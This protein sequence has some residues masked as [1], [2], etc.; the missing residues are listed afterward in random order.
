MRSDGRRDVIGII[1]SF[2][3]GLM[4]AAFFG[5]G[6][7]TFYPMPAPYDEEFEE[8]YRREQEVRRLAPDSGLTEEQRQLIDDI[9]AERQ[10]LYQARI[11]LQDRWARNA[12]IILTVLATAAM[13]ISLIRTTLP[14]ISNGLLLGGIFTI[15][16]GIG[17]VA[18]SDDALLSFLS[19]TVALAV[20]LLVGYLR[21]GKQQQGTRGPASAGPVPGAGAGSPD[22][23]AIER[24]L[25]ELERRLDR[26]ARALDSGDG[27]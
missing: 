4:L 15:L 1:F 20:T 22:L 12:S 7:H 25:A 27:P 19:V 16:Y 21:F 13:A 14:V 2:F 8:L 6:L 23:A 18:S 24:R 17:W 9:I 5:I 10:E 11:K 26:A 3:L